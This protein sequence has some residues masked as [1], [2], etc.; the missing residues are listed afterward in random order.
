MFWPQA[1]VVISIT[2]RVVQKINDRLV[3]MNFLLQSVM[4][5]VLMFANFY[6]LLSLVQGQASF[7]VS[8]RKDQSPSQWTLIS[9]AWTFLFFSTVVQSTTG[10]GDVWAVSSSARL[11]VTIH[12]LTSTLYAVAVVGLGI[13]QIMSSEQAVRRR[14]TVHARNMEGLFNSDCLQ[15]RGEF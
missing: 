11:L 4:S 2:V 3:S 9:R 14:S 15:A 5:T 12:M 8:S 1:F 7:R 13:S 6:L 10:Y